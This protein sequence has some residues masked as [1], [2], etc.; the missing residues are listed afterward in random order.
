MT[1]Q[2]TSPT[3][4][5]RLR[6][7][8]DQEAWRLFETIYGPLI[9]KYCARR[10]IQEHDIDDLTQ[11]VLTAVSNAMP[12]FDYQPERGRFRAWLG[13]I[14]A[15]KVKRFFRKS[16]IA[17]GAA[18]GEGEMESEVPKDPD[19]EWVSVF[20]ERIL[21]V[22]CDRVRDQVESKTWQ[23]FEMLWSRGKSVAEVAQELGITVGM[24]Y[25]NKSRVMKRL[26]EELILLSH[27]LPVSSVLHSE[28]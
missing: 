15:N 6:R 10:G 26:E 7:T 14:T 18:C 3:L 24:V 28:S 12:D 23:T 5:S 13:T 17:T 2:T 8:D 9:R 1:E 4:I 19:S 16:K 21:E 22:A 20:S 11:D 25:V 27:D